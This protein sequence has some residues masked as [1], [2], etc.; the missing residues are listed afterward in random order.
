MIAPGLIVSAPRSGAGKTTVTL[1]ILAALRRQGLKV[2]AAK[3]GPDYIDPAFHQAATGRQ[4]FNLDSWAMSPELIDALLA[5][6][7]SG[8]DLL[9]IE[10]GMGLFDGI[11]GAPRRTGASADLAARLS[12]PV[13]LVI[14]VAGQSQSAAALVRGFASHD[15][16]V[17]IGGVVLNRA[18]SERHGKLVSDA[19]PAPRIPT[20]GAHPRPPGP[21]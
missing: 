16:Q 19:L 21:V 14:D 18:G 9:V 17:R 7:G 15:P 5:R 13:V 3:A 1:A 6:G 11:P 20:R 2:Q 8:A 4:S 12:L 10:G